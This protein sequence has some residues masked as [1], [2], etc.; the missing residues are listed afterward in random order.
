MILKT[1]S[2]GHIIGYR[3]TYFSES[4]NVSVS[5]IGRLNT[6]TTTDRKTGKV[7]IQTVF[8][9]AILPTPQGK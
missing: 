7:E 6:I 9:Q 4:Q 3:E 1:G 5:V 8:G 2:S